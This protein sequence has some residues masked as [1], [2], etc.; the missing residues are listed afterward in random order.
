[1]GGGGGSLSISLP[2]QRTPLFPRNSVLSNYVELNKVL[3]D[4]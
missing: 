4:T 1:M 3:I 2:I